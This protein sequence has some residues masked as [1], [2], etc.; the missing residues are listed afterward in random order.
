MAK[1]MGIDE[2]KRIEFLLGCG[3]KVAQI[4]VE[5]GRPGSTVVREIIA[6]RIDSDKRLG[7]SNRLCARFDECMRRV[8]TGFGERLRKNQPRCFETCPDFFESHCPRLARS[9]YVCNGCES[10]RNCPMRKKYYLA[11]APRPTTRARSSTAASACAWERRPSR[12]WTRSCRPASA[13]GSPS[14]TS[15]RT[16]P[17]RSET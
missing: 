10:E 12:R 15:S 13:G 1:H 8:F 14:A 16:T 5:V 11:P 6:R 4:A 7:C 9:P 17:A 3:M 2:R